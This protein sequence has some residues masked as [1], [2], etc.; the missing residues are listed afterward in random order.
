PA[1]GFSADKLLTYAAAAEKG[2]EHP[3]GEAI[4]RGAAQRDITIAG[5]E[6]FNAI[7]GHGVEARVDGATVLLGNAKL[8]REHRI[9]VDA[10]S[11]EFESLSS[12]GKTVVY[13][14]V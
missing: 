6:H 4:V 7:G 1:D 3:L 9:T 13:V 5:A 12:A 10:H 8:M 11:T 2:S 14:A